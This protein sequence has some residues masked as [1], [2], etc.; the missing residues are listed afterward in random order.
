MAETI[1]REDVITSFDESS[2]CMGAERCKKLAEAMCAFYRFDNQNTIAT[3]QGMIHFAS[4]PEGPC[5]NQGELFCQDR[6]ETEQ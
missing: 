1:T 6:I 2:K 4:M 5:P 3:G